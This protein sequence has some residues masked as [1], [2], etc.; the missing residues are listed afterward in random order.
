MTAE[1]LMKSTS[2]EV[3]SK[4]EVGQQIIIAY[5]GSLL[6]GIIER[7]A[8]DTVIVKCMQKSIVLSSLWDWPVYKEVHDY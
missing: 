3:T 5:E 1:K 6:P 4:Y 8:G 7:F 2:Y